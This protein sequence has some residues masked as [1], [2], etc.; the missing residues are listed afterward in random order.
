MLLRHIGDAAAVA[1]HVVLGLEEDAADGRGGAAPGP[2]GFQLQPEAAPNFPGGKGGRRP[3]ADAVGGGHCGGR[4]PRPHGGVRVVGDGPGG[5][6]GRRAG[7]SGSLPAEGW[8]P[9]VGGGR[10]PGLA[11]EAAVEDAAHVGLE[12]GPDDE[13]A[14]EECRHRPEGD[15][16]AGVVEGE[17]LRPLVDVGGD[18]PV[19][20]S[21]RVGLVGVG[22]ADGGQGVLGGDDGLVGV[23]R[24]GGAAR[25]VLYN[26]LALILR[27]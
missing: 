18:V 15:P 9:G 20:G 5:V 16:D 4:G 6:D 7:Q 8:P 21:R 26:G 2:R 17:P 1:G 27:T 25:T 14:E 3:E 22:V 10:L 13:E 24:G 19:G 11:H 12:A 23:L